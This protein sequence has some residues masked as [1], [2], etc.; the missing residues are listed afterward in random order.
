MESKLFSYLFVESIHFLG[1]LIGHLC[2]HFH[3]LLKLCQLH[4]THLYLIACLFSQQIHLLSQ[5]VN[6][7]LK[8]FLNLINFNVNL[9]LNSDHLLSK[10]I[11]YKSKWGHFKLKLSKFFVSVQIKCSDVLYFILFMKHAACLWVFIHWKRLYSCWPVKT[12]MTCQ[13]SLLFWKIILIVSYP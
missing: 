10:L 8:L 7:L 12:Q 6:T 5:V 4:F 2:K 11:C 3:F 1:K 9:L 13:Y